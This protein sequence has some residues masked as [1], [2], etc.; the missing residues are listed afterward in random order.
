MNSFYTQN[1]LEK[2]GFASL[3]ESVQISRKAS[4][5]SAGQISIGNHVRI[6]DFCILSGRIS[7]GNYIHISAGTYLFAGDAGITF[8]DY[9]GIS[10][11][12]AI[13][14]ITDDYSGRYLTNSTVEELYRGVIAK[15]VTIGRFS[16]IGTG[17]TVLPG[18][19]IGEGCAFGAMS[20]INKSTEPWGIYLGI[21]CKRVKE[22]NKMCVN[23]QSK[24]RKYGGRGTT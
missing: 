12:G 20:L 21:P 4:I 8:E 10:S 23:L 11:R 14:A 18:V 7:L 6:D 19:S 1:E 13:Y 9:S 16:I 3:G 15:A 2:I 24:M 22:R 5:Y 17:C